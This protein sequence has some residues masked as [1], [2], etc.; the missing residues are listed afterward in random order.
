V[1]GLL[2]SREGTS[3][4]VFFFVTSGCMAILGATPA[5]ADEL[6]IAPALGLMDSTTDGTELVL[7]LATLMSTESTDGALLHPRIQLQHV[8]ASGFGAYAGISAS[9]L[10]GE[11]N[12]DGSIGNLDLGGLYQHRITPDVAIGART[13]LLI[14]TASNGESANLISTLL[15]RPG[16]IATAVPGTWLRLGGSVRFRAGTGFMGL[17][18]GVDVPVGSDGRDPIVHL[19]AGAGFNVEHWSVTAELGTVRM[20]SGSLDSFTVIGVAAHHHGEPAS[21]Y[22]MISMPVEH[23]LAGRIITLTLGAAF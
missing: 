9:E 17:D 10:F 1:A 18:A 8:A 20:T 21:P 2:A 15:A 23:L 12:D 22:V 11:G 6:P 13:G 19:N 5:F 4:R 16:D 7:E 3:M 14:D